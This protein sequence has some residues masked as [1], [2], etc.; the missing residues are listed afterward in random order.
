[1]IFLPY[2]S[3]F[4][5]TLFL[6][7]VRLM[8]SSHWLIIWTILE[9]NI[10]SF[11][12][13]IVRIKLYREA[14]ARIKY[15]LFQ[16]LGALII[17]V[18]FIFPFNMGFMW[19]GLII[20]LGAAPLHFWFP[21]VIRSIRWSNCIILTT[22]Q[23]LGPLIVLTFTQYASIKVFLIIV[24]IA[25]ALIGRLGGLNQS[26]TRLLLTYSSI[27]HLSWILAA[28][29]KNII[30]III[31]FT[32]YR[33]I[34]ARLMY[35]LWNENIISLKTHNK[36]ILNTITLRFLLLS[37][38]GLPPLTGFFIKWIVI[39]NLIIYLIPPLLLRS[40]INIF[41]YLNVII[42]IIMTAITCTN[43][44][45]RY[46]W[47]IIRLLIRFIGL[48]FIFKITYALTLFY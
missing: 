5:S 18:A 6:R 43:N 32:I 9:V 44:K 27:S 30:S 21:Y 19:I 45:G 1:M 29:I 35:V 15:F 7:T 28:I 40:T 48:P 23:K 17:L 34:T 14:E 41:F 36:S 42:S 47:L 26:Q 8:A 11:I 4:I 33:V 46:K 10:I 2:Y 13:L 3:L 20:K 39:S 16:V 12:P 38:G 25:S 22:W 24:A 31:Y 37:L